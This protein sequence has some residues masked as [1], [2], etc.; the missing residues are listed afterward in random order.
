MKCALVLGATGQDGQLLSNFL[1]K[2]GYTVF[3]V[4]RNNP[5]WSE[6]P[7]KLD[8]PTHVKLDMTKYQQLSSLIEDIKPQEIYN[9]SASSS[10]SSSFSD[11]AGT[12]SSNVL[13]VLN[14]LNSIKNFKLEKVVKIFHPSSSDMFGSSNSQLNENSPMFPRSPYGVAKLTAHQI[15]IQYRNEFGVQVSTGIL[16]NHESELR[17]TQF[18]FQKII[19]SLVEI[20]LGR[21]K[22]VELGNLNIYRDWGYAG[23]YIKV[24]HKILQQAESSDYVIATG[25]LHSL[26]DI[27]IQSCQ[28]LSLK[29]DFD[30]LVHIDNLLSRPLDIERTWGDPSRINLELGWK[31]N[32]SFEELIEK[33]IKFNLSKF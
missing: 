29:R 33:M 16:F 30:S 18:V 21:R 13:G 9:L 32:T 27:I 28:K 31:A 23:D 19:H 24:M 5:N 22:Y 17:S 3:G 20:S 2:S 6:N 12:T 1:L 4:S 14:L 11:P 7:L 8:R 25:N 15:C 26:T 10:V